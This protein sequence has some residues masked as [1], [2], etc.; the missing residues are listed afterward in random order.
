MLW[1]YENIEVLKFKENWGDLR[2]KKL[3]TD[4]H[5]KNWHDLNERNQPKF[6]RTKK[7]CHLFLHNFLLLWPKSYFWKGDRVLGPDSN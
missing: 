3:L 4:N 2:N 5:C 6:D 1:S 7:P